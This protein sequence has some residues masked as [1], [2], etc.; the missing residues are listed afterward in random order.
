MYSV[1]GWYLLTEGVNGNIVIIVIWGY[2]GAMDEGCH[3]S[4]MVTVSSRHPLVV[5]KRGTSFTYRCRAAKF[6]CPVIPF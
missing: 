2:P 4:T 6:I 5:C 3:R 1:G